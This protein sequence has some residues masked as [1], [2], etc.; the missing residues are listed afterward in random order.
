MSG[1][2]QKHRE[3]RVTCRS[4]AAVTMLT[5]LCSAGGAHGQSAPAAGRT[6]PSETCTPL[7]Q[8]RADASA[9]RPNVR[10]DG[11]PLPGVQPPDISRGFVGIPRSAQ[12]S[13]LRRSAGFSNAP[14]GFPKRVLICRT[15]CSFHRL[16]T[17]R[18]QRRSSSIS[19]DTTSHRSSKCCSTARL[20]LLNVM[21]SSSWR[22]WATASPRTGACVLAR[23]P[24]AARPGQVAANIL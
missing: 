19:T 20:T 17:P 4:C 22:P 18:H 5:V 1:P 10:H 15:P 11:T 12:P 9:G 6:G 8:A 13:P 21:G 3:S 14:I 16:T 23:W 2:G 7:T 24:R